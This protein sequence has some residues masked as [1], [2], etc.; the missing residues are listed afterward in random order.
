[1]S[2]LQQGTSSVDA[3]TTRLRV[4]STMSAYPH[5]PAPASA[6]LLDGRPES[7]IIA[8]LR[9]DLAAAKAVD[10]R[11]LLRRAVKRTFDVSVAATGLLLTLPTFI[12]VALLIK[13]DSP[14]PVFYRAERVGFRGRSLKVLKFRKMHAD[15]RGPALTADDD[16]R[17]TRAGAFLARTKLDEL[18]QLWNVLIGDMSL[19]GPRPEDPRFVALHAEE[20]SN[21]LL[22]RP[23]MTGL[24]QIAFAAESRILD[25]VDPTGHYLDRIL[26][27]KLA[28]DQ[29]YA[30]HY[31]VRIDISIL[32]WTLVAVCLRREVAVHRQT[33]RMN[34]RRRRRASDRLEQQHQRPTDEKRERHLTVVDV[35]EVGVTGVDA[36]HDVSA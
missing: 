25:D 27:Q 20:F 10:A 26:P 3:N 7:E 22:V 16:Q 9:S 19:I 35:T 1:M 23:G 32:I 5:L 33:G 17:F 28:L 34:V 6:P 2:L 12:I 14:G 18:P 4:L 36:T 21:V 11:D 31:H 8:G 24:S 13:L 29:M 30:M 15:A